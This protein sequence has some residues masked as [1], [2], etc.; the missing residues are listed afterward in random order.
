MKSI[1]KRVFLLIAVVFLSLSLFAACDTDIPWGEETTISPSDCLSHTDAD[2]NG[3]CD[4]CNSDVI[5]EIDLYAINDLHGKLLDSDSQPGVDELTTYLKEAFEENE[6]SVLFSVGDMWQGSAESGLTRGNMMTDWM[7]M[8]DFSFM[9]LGN[10]EFD[11]GDRYIEE[12]GDIADFPFLAINVYDSESGERAD[13]CEPSVTI[14]LGEVQIGFIGA[15]GD[16][17]SSISGDMRDGYY[18]AVGDELT[19]LVENESDKLRNEGVDIIVYTLHD[20]TSGCDESLTAEGYVDIVFEGHSHSAYAKIDK[21]GV[22]HIQGGG[23]NTGM[24]HAEI[25][26][27]FAN[28]SFDV[29]AE[30]IKNRKYS[31]CSSDT[32]VDILMDKYSE[33]S[34]LLSSAV[35]TNSRQRYSNELKDLVAQRYASLAGERWGEYD[36][37]LG[38][39]FISCRSPGRL[40]AGEVS[41]AELYMLFPFDNRLALCSCTGEDLLDNYINTSNKNYFV[42]YTDY[43]ESVRN[44]IDANKTYYIITDS[45][46]YTYAPN[47]LTVIE[48]YDDITYARDLV[49]EY[50]QCGGMLE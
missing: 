48:I 47:N 35:G 25:E 4:S 44:T 16:C 3:F 12:N 6:N 39:G 33:E 10:H 11:W 7:N 41:Y 32:I 36:I 20:S 22:Y 49:A 9:T 46:N 5:L 29:D 18:F 19:A 17:Y 15:I 21:N 8:L 40:D 31:A 30:V 50:I 34:E 2:D 27:N 45:Y 28:Q 23:E 24:S 42:S 13:F 37:V 14:D 26:Y 43:G 38:G 1:D